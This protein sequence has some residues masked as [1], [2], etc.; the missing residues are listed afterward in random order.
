MADW[1]KIF[2]FFMNYQ[3]HNIA[4]YKHSASYKLRTGKVVM[5]CRCTTYECL[6]QL[7]I[8]IIVFSARL[9]PS[10]WSDHLSLVKNPY[11]V[12]A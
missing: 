9:K 11:P 12:L 2:P 8:I 3:S 6:V 4:L 7:I 1:T 10:A 5:F